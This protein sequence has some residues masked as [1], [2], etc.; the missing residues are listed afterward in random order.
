MTK[1]Q[2]QSVGE[3]VIKQFCLSIAMSLISS[4]AC[5]CKSFTNLGQFLIN[6]IDLTQTFG[7][8]KQSII[9]AINDH[10]LSVYQVKDAAVNKLICQINPKYITAQQGM[11]PFYAIIYKTC[12]RIFMR[13]DLGLMYHQCVHMVQ[14]LMDP[15]YQSAQYIF[16]QDERIVF[17]NKLFGKLSIPSESFEYE[18]TINTIR[19]INNLLQRIELRKLSAIISSEKIIREQLMEEEKQFQ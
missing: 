11:T 17:V 10:C 3:Y 4:C 12:H 13:I 7:T 16:K 9:Q 2:S 6:L 19:C 18:D 8:D 5:D 15:N 14:K 1:L